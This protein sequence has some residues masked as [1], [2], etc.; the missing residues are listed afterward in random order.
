MDTNDRWNKFMTTGSV[1]DYLL[2]KE[3]E[4]KN[5]MSNV[6]GGTNNN[7]NRNSK[8]MYTG[9]NDQDIYGNVYDHSSNSEGSILNADQAG[10]AGG[11]GKKCKRK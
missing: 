10:W 9:D 6:Y 4:R 3:D 5:M 1:R 11:F 7:E 2:F 8:N